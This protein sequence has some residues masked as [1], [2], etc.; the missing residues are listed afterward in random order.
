MKS[1]ITS[2]KMVMCFQD[3]TR[4]DAQRM[5]SLSSLFLRVSPYVTVPKLQKGISFNLILYSFTKCRNIP[6]SLV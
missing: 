2:E 1:D 6:V 4:G 5:R 3:L